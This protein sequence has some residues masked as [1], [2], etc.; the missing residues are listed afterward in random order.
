MLSSHAENSKAAGF[1]SH[2]PCWGG[3]SFG[4]SDV[5]GL[6]MLLEEIPRDSLVG[7]VDL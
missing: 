7:Q 2:H 3:A 1:L 4:D 6:P 5:C